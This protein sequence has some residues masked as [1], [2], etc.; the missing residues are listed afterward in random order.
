MGSGLM[1]ISQNM[2]PPRNR[3][4]VVHR[5]RGVVLGF[6]GGLGQKTSRKF[7]AL[8]AT[9]GQPE[10][11]LHN[12]IFFYRLLEKAQTLRKPY[13]KWSLRSMIYFFFNQ[14]RIFDKK[15]G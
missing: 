12:A 7:D 11:G 9:P 1:T 10:L 6:H 5:H 2:G 4:G 15:N 3:R 14:G 8:S 13:K